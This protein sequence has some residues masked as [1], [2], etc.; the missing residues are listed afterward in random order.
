M[1]LKN[2][3]IEAI[4]QYTTLG[5]IIPLRIRMESENHELAI[6]KISDIVYKKESYF[7]GLKTLDYGCR[8]EGKKSEHLL[9]IRYYIETHKWV[10]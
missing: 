10:I 9:E 8:V 2:I 3:P 1:G 6:F 4:C 5:E 7:A